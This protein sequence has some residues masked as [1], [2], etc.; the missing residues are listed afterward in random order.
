MKHE[1]ILGHRRYGS[2]I[3]G[4]DTELDGATERALVRDFGTLEA[5]WADPSPFEAAKREGQRR[6]NQAFNPNA[7]QK[8]QAIWDKE[9]Q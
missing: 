1:S 5:Y 7:L 3:H 2:A 6:L 8:M 4:P 9:G